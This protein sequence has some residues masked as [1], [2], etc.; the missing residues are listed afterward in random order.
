MCSQVHADPGIVGPS[1]ASE[2]PLILDSRSFRRFRLRVTD[3]PASAC[4]LRAPELR[5]GRAMTCGAMPHSNFGTLIMF[6]ERALARDAPARRTRATNWR[7][8]LPVGASG[9]RRFQVPLAAASQT[10]TS[11]ASPALSAVL[12]WSET[13]NSSATALGTAP[14]IV[15]AEDRVSTTFA[16]RTVAAPPG[17]PLRTFPITPALCSSTAGRTATPAIRPRATPEGSRRRRRPRR[18]R[19]AGLLKLAASRRS[20]AAGRNPGLSF[21]PPAG[22]L[23]SRALR[24]FGAGYR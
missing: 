22:I 24:S 11:I 4:R 21:R 7:L 20:P 13:G 23:L 3:A 14:A 8:A 18:R 19:F 2:T 1:T 5:R 9:V 10:A 6:D 12:G 17:L 16:A 15:E